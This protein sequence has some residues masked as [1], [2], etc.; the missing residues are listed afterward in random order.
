MTGTEDLPDVA[1]EVLVEDSEMERVMTGM[2]E[3]KEEED[4]EETRA[5]VCVFF[6]QIFEFI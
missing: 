3:M 4:L 1:V 5:E 6:L 2:A